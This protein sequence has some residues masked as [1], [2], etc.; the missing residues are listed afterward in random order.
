[1]GRPL[2]IFRPFSK[3][4]GLFFL[5]SIRK[6]LLL[7]II[8][9]LAGPM[10]FSMLHAVRTFGR[11]IEKQAHEKVHSDL[12][13]L[14]MIYENKQ[15]EME[16]FA[17]SLASRNVVKVTVG[18]GRESLLGKQLGEYLG[19][20]LQE[21]VVDMIT[22]TDAEGKVI[23]RG[24]NPQARDDDLSS[25]D[26]VKMALK[27]EG[28]VGTQLISEEEL[29]KEGLAFKAQ[30]ETQNIYATLMIQAGFPIYEED[31]VMG[32]VLVGCLINHNSGL[33]VK[34]GDESNR[35]FAVLQKDRIVL[36]NVEDVDKDDMP[37]HREKVNLVM[38]PEEK[39][40][41]GEKEKPLW[42]KAYGLGGKD[43]LT[44]FSILQNITGEEVGRLMALK[45]LESI[46]GL[47]KQ[48]IFGMTLI[49]LLG[50][51]VAILSAGFFGYKV[52]QPINQLVKGTERIAQGDLETLIQVNSRDEIGVLANSFNQ[53]TSQL[54]KSKVE[55][56]Q[57]S[58]NLENLVKKRTKELEFQTQRAVQADQLKSQFLANTSH[59]FRTPLNSILGF[60]RLILDGYCN[61]ESEQK[62]F[63]QNAHA[64]AK[65]LLSLINDV[66]DI[67]KIEAGKLEL[68]LEEVD[69]KALF[70][71][72]NSLTRVQV[73]QKKL[74]MSF[75]CEDEFVPKIYA[76]LG[77]LKQVMLNLIGNA[78]KF[79]DK[80]SVTIRTRVQKD[81]GNVLI[82][83]EDT[84]IGVAPE[85]RGRL[86]KKFS[87]VDGSY[88]RKHGGTGLGLTISKSLVE[89]M[90]GKINLE[91]P[92]ENQGCTI[93][94]TVPIF[95][96]TTKEALQEKE[97]PLVIK[98]NKDAPLV[99][100]VEDDPV[101]VRFL[102][103][104]LHQEGFSSI[105]AATADDAVYATRDYH[106]EIITLDYSLPKKRKGSLRNGRDV[107]RE[108]QKDPTTK[109]IETIIISGQDE[110][111][112]KE[113]L[114]F[115]T[116]TCFP[117]V[118]EKPIDPEV[119]MKKIKSLLHKESSLTPP[120]EKRESL[121]ILVADD[122]PLVRRFVAKILEPE[123]DIIHQ[124]VDGQ[125]AIDFISEHKDKVDL[126]LLDL[127]MPKKSGID[128]IRELKLE[129]KAPHLPIIVIT[130]HLDAYEEKEKELLS[131]KTVL[132]VITKEELN[133]D[134]EIL[135]KKIARHTR[136][137]KTLMV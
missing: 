4:A 118:L 56:E 93:S 5:S 83:V 117:E 23:A 34:L 36:T 137:E 115:E 25:L 103:K 110:N 68:E 78:I 86:F 16:T 49:F 38:G 57:Y 11:F 87:Q 52:T 120:T 66:L 65:H 60:L 48:A 8:L 105:C 26:L 35:D 119:L 123:G 50:L 6:K 20:M 62:E 79:T 43:Y 109:D 122:D 107:I 30:P 97:K 129:R 54:R 21:N 114:S 136:K 29:I 32:T 101:Y 127:M 46:T 94:F 99:L 84:G 44:H 31:K 51:G 75:I 27:G 22:V 102:E 92:G 91:S 55:L 95:R 2:F 77:K 18:L 58:R 121:N 106:P 45:D 85:K 12:V 126:L 28:G 133:Q 76:D 14:T 80:G 24:T 131:R 15:K 47:Q 40:P 1:M 73:E 59:E 10:A 72:V 124:A 125:Q 132:E 69:L 128:V 112:I 100:I 130:A 61:D 67:A 111:L 98:G 63:I 82:Q 90:G 74:K 108:L 104:I 9:L 135:K 53:M 41:Y 113:E 64:S 116:I 39:T 13:S 33:A 3:V 89:M 88:T 71:E 19:K 37:L 42:G 7:F 70:E 134:P 81:K 17:R 96:E